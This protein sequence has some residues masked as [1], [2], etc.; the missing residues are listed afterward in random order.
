MRAT[1]ASVSENPATIISLFVASAGR[2]PYRVDRAAHRGGIASAFG[3]D[4]VTTSPF[5]RA[6]SA[7]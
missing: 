1:R 5:L 7:N 2:F 6:L 4:W 3:A